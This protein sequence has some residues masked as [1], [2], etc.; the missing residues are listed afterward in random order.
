MHAPIPYWSISGSG[1]TGRPSAS[2][3]ASA[4]A[5]GT[6]TFTAWSAAARPTTCCHQA[7]T[8]RQASPARSARS[9]RPSEYTLP[10]PLSACRT[11]SRPSPGRQHARQDSCLQCNLTEILATDHRQSFP[12][13]HDSAVRPMISTWISVI[14]PEPCESL[15][16]IRPRSG[17]HF[18]RRDL[19]LSKTSS[20]VM[21]R[22]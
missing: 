2:A 12:H 14:P 8:S 16:Q 13:S 17:G 22:P 20:G 15:M 6:S 5:G 3:A 11:R 18:R 1:S 21:P 9:F 7:T 10:A 19:M 4:S